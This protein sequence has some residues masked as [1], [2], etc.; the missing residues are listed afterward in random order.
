MDIIDR[1]ILILTQPKNKT[2]THVKS[3]S[4]H[5]S[6]GRSRGAWLI[7]VHI[8]RIIEQPPFFGSCWKK[9]TTEKTLSEL[10]ISGMTFNWILAKLKTTKET[11][12]K[13]AHLGG[14]AAAACECHSDQAVHKA[15][16]AEPQRKMSH[17]HIGSIQKEPANLV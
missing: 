3:I 8:G 17:C 6:I 2:R 16:N 10:L 13:R 15:A 9:T 1:C 7:H 12:D 4:M 11:A 14:A 5:V